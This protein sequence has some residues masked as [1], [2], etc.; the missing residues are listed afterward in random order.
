MSSKISTPAIPNGT[1]EKRHS[2]KDRSS[3]GLTE[4]AFDAASIP[5]IDAQGFNHCL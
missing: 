4:Q 1:F 3:Y 2:E 5:T